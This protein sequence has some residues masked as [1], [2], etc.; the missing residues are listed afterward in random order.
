MG[1]SEARKEGRLRT[2]HMLGP[3]FPGRWQ[4]VQS[5]AYDVRRGWLLLAKRLLMPGWSVDT[6][7]IKGARLHRLASMG[8]P[9]GVFAASSL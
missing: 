2:T 9:S 7:S 4:R 3:E 1:G 6:H 5:V 8:T